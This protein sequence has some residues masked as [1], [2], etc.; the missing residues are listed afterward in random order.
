MNYSHA[1]NENVDTYN[2]IKA[3]RSQRE[4]ACCSWHVWLWGVP[5]SQGCR[6]QQNEKLAYHSV[7]GGTAFFQSNK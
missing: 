5:S 4:E 7:A 6:E 1:A 2:K 3:A